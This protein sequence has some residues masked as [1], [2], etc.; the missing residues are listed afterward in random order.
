MKDYMR[1]RYHN[2]RNEAIEK[3]GGKCVYCGDNTQ[4]QFDHIK[5]EDKLYEI[6]SL[7]S[8]SE[9]KFL[10]EIEKCQ[11][12]CIKCHQLKTISDMGMKPAKGTHGTLSSFRYC[13][14]VLCKTAKSDYMKDYKKKRKKYV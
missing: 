6:G 8:I 1:K 2:K 7:S 14:C 12:L 13:K 3:L 9:E 10:K 4:L 11:L 5:P